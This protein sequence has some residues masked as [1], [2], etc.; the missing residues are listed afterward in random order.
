MSAKSR[1]REV[2]F[3]AF[4][5]YSGSREVAKL[6][7]SRLSKVGASPWRLWQWWNLKVFFDKEQ[8]RVGDDLPEAISNAV[9]GSRYF[10][11]LA[12]KAAARSKWVSKELEFWLASRPAADVLIVV[13]DGSIG[14][15]EEAMDFDWSMTDCIPPILKGKYKEECWEDLRRFSPPVRARADKEKLREAVASLGAKILD[16]PREKLL[17]DERRKHRYARAAAGLILACLIASTAFAGRLWLKAVT[18]ADKLFNDGRAALV[19]R[20]NWGHV[21][22]AMNS[23]ERALKEDPKHVLALLG[24]ADAHI[25]LIG[26][27]G[28]EDPAEGLRAAQEALKLAKNY[29]AE[30]TSE[31][32]RVLG[33]LLLY[34]DRDVRG[35]HASLTMAVRLD[36]GNVDAVYAL[37]S[38]YTYVGQHGEAIELCRRALATVREQG[39]AEND[40]KYIHAQV[41]LAWTYFYAG[42]IEAA[43]ALSSQILDSEPSSAPPNRFL[44]HARIITGEYK[45]AVENYRAAI[46]HNL[47]RDPN[48]SKNYREP[49]LFPNYVCALAR[50]GQL[51]KQDAKRELDKLPGRV[52][53]VS[54]FRLAQ[55]YACIGETKEA[56]AQLRRARDNHDLFVVWSAVDPLLSS[57]RGE[58]EFQEHLGAVGLRGVTLSAFDPAERAKG[59][60]PWGASALFLTCLTI[61]AVLAVHLAKGRKAEEICGKGQARLAGRRNSADVQNALGKFQRAIELDPAHAP[62]LLGKAEALILLVGYS[63]S[64]DPA[65]D[66]EEARTALARAGRCGCEGTSEY[67]Y[68][69]GRI[70]LYKDRDIRGART[71]L[72]QAIKLDPR[73][74][75]ARHALAGTYTFLEQHE[76][77]IRVCRRALDIA[78]RLGR[79]E[80]DKGVV[81]SK[82]LLAWTYYYAGMYDLAERWCDEILAADPAHGRAK[83]FLCHIYTQKKDYEKALKKYVE[84]GAESGGDGGLFANYT[85]ALALSGQSA[86]A[87]KNIGALLAGTKCASPYRLAQCYACVGET[88]RALALL[89]RARDEGDLFVLWAR[90]DPLLL[91]LRGSDAFEQYLAS[92]GLREPGV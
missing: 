2:E 69:E 85:C 31:Y 64:A 54:P 28:T 40:A 74:L 88:G 15:D 66:I 55:G 59:G 10:V 51:S 61:S 1:E 49:N 90:V 20:K 58:P 57:L 21:L 12:S 9:R 44:A 91:G 67:H 76:A 19:G 47:S 92:V 56:L 32:H 62:A 11:L 36:P 72:M 33:R 77:A 52:K 89:E 25:L 41:Q 37:A 34:K 75:G 35:A 71:S 8:I 43:V 60:R 83:K 16:V 86:K 3:A 73:H 63:A 38:T 24:L 27:G 45:A 26:F 81:L 6:I 68:V 17:S 79:G 13:L 5:S 78:L 53:Y 50:D 70:L 82:L 65:G 87:A 48:L 80:G 29:G 18:P 42:D 46:G 84:S 39:Y 23:F 22:S 30:D 7:F 14:W 4:I